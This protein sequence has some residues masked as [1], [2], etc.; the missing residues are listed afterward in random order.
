MNDAQTLE[1]AADAAARIKKGSHLLDWFAI[2]AG[3][4]VGVR[5]AL[6]ETGANDKSNK[7]YQNAF[8]RWMKQH[9]WT[10]DFNQATRT[11]AFWLDDNHVEIE[12]F[13]STLDTNKRLKMNHPTVVRRV[14]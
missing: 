11:H 13:L 4:N 8:G 12:E 3:F 1:F 2:G 5:F 9:P 7:L 6:A 10:G 14:G